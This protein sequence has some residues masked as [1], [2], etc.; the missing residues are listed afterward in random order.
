MVKGRGIPPPSK[1]QC[2][3][4][5]SDLNSAPF[6]HFWWLL[7]DSKLGSKLSNSH[8]ILQ[9]MDYESSHKH[10]EAFLRFFHYLDVIGAARA[11]VYVHICLDDGGFTAKFGPWGAKSSSRYFFF[12]FLHC[13]TIKNPPQEHKYNKEN[14]PKIQADKTKWKKIKKKTSRKWINI[15]GNVQKLRCFH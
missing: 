1:T 15:H 4:L 6:L 12:Y 11:S 3:C 5:N 9:T 13:P 10:P 2:S 14:F 7:E 8:R